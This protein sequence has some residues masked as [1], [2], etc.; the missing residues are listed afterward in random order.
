MV[1]TDGSGAAS[2]SLVSV[3]D[4]EKH[5]SITS[6]AL[7]TEVGRVHAVDG[8]S[9]DVRR[10]ETFGIVGESGCGKST[11]ARALLR[12]DEPTGGEIRFDGEDLLAY[13]DAA[14]RR[15][16]RRAQL[17]FQ[18][19]DSSFDP[20]MSVGDSV[21]EPLVVQG[22]TDRERREAIVADLLERVGLDPDERNRYPHEFSGGQKQ[23]LALARALTVNPDL[24]VADEPTSAL[25]VSVQST[26]LDLLAG[27]Q[28]D[29][30]VTVVIISHDMGVIRQVCDRVAVMY[31]GEFVEVGP[32][33]RVFAD[34]QHPYT[35]A[36]L[37]AVPTPDPDDRGLGVGLTGS[38]PDPADPPD[39]CRFHT[40]CPDVIPPEG[41]DLPRETWRSLL[42][43]RTRVAA[44]AV[45]LDRIVEAGVLREPGSTLEGDDADEGDA[46]S[47]DVASVDAA[48]V[49]VD[50]AD[51]DPADLKRWIRE[52]H[53]LPG[54]IGDPA[55]E[56]D[57]AA[58]LDAL[59]A[60]DPEAAT[61][62]LA[63]RLST[64]CA[65]EK[66]EFR[67]ADD[68]RAA[69]HLLE[70]GLVGADDAEADA[71]FGD[72]GARDGSER[73]GFADRIDVDAFSDRVDRT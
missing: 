15:F 40:R 43:F 32:T 69:C 71:S 63:D 70:E 38:V 5:Y 42:G 21:A 51:V 34:P 24:L 7:A 60:D 10:G 50:P 30:G 29:L 72:A 35:R 2:D 23:R 16:R 20:R 27:F 41:V 17:L 13:D 55:V 45:D 3:T 6:G 8:V 25:D 46:D 65:R 14:L 64:V 37:S 44:G 49:D 66:P 19:P 47:A 68:H 62:A 52:E 18:D 31:L 11:L 26:V 1:R 4:L 48:S 22:L 28:Q 59:V 9:F 12:L 67:V 39:G 36:L 54:R 53:D 58:A 57:L 61:A 33:E 56:A 73:D